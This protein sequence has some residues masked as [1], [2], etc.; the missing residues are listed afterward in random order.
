MSSSAKVPNSTIII[1]IY[2]DVKALAV[3]LYALQRQSEKQFSIIISEDGESPEV[4]RFLAQQKFTHPLLHL[5]QS[6]EGFRKNRALNRAVLA[7]PNDY[8]VFIDG[9]C[10]PHRHFIHAHTHYAQKGV[11]NCGRRIELGKHYSTMLREDATALQLLDGNLHYL[12]HYN[13]LRR[14]NTKNVELGFYLPTVQRLMRHRNSSIIGCNFSLYRDDLLAVNGFDEAYH[15]PGIGED[16]D[17]E[18][19]LRN[20]GVRMLSNKSVA[21]QYHLY[22]PRGY[23]VSEENKRLLKEAAS[24]IRCHQG[25]DAHTGDQG[26]TPATSA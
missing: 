19:R 25:I 24:S 2:Q 8:L 13:A 26:G 15:T 18:Q 4:A 14:D 1:S 22:H 5:T 10:V 23:S 20:N 11:V 7:A 16:S 21:I 17:L 3:I 6:D 12:R 9:D